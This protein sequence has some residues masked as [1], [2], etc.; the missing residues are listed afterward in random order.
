MGVRGG[1]GARRYS[2]HF[3]AQGKIQG[4]GDFPG[5]PGVKNLPCNAED[6]D[7]IPDQGPK[8]PH[9]VQPLSPHATVTESDHHKERS[10]RT[11]SRPDAAK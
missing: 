10:C 11:Q 1:G 7:S 3:T 4:K 8:V 2:S 5:G 9:A 6:Q